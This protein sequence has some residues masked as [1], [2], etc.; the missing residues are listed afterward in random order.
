MKRELFVGL[1]VLSAAAHGQA[2]PS[3][4]DTLDWMKNTL[5]P[6]GITYTDRNGFSYHSTPGDGHYT[7]LINSFSYRQCQVKIVKRI[8]YVSKALFQSERPFLSEETDTFSLSDIDPKSVHID[9]SAYED[10]RGRVVVLSTTDD[11]KAIHCQTIN[12]NPGKDYGKDAGC[13]PAL[14]DTEQL[15]FATAEYAERFAKALKHAV[16]LCGGKPSAF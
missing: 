15:R 2:G 12:R 6:K 1:L 10:L 14:D 13:V 5:A 16:G 11:K 7:E 8:E 9:D 3:L 4:T